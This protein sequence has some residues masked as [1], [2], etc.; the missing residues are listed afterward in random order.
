VITMASSHAAGT[1]S[2]PV[3][4]SP[5]KQAMERATQV[6]APGGRAGPIAF[7]KGGGIGRSDGEQPEGDHT[8]DE[9][10]GPRCDGALHLAGEG[11]ARGPGWGPR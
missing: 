10:R 2:G 5:L 4:A 9:Q 11:P 6:P 8:D 1:R 3:T 7:Q